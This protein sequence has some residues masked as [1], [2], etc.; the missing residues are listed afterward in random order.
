MLTIFDCDGVLVDSELIALAELSRMMGAFGV[1]M[2]VAAC[3]DAFM[4]LHN[5]DIIAAIETRI[6]RALPADEGSRMRLRMIERMKHELKP[7]AGVAATLRRLGGARCVASSSD[8]ERIALTLRLTGLDGFFGDHLFSG[9]EVARGK[10]A[11]DLFLLAAE[12]MGFAP[13]DCVV[14][15]DAV[16]G[17]RAGIAAGMRVIGFTG[18]SHTNAGHAARLREAGASSIIV[19]MSALPAA[20]APIPVSH[21]A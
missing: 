6:G 3:Q 10:P 9:T 15:E 8:R 1:P 13:T 21:L 19:H 16:A 14:V 12:T 20:L 4:G 18:G 17:V 11:P 7:V 5:A 2:S